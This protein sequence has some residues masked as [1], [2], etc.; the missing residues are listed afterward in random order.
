MYRVTSTIMLVA[1]SL[2][3]AAQGGASAVQLPAQTTLPIVFTSTV[4]AKGAHTGDPV[5]AKTFQT[6]HLQNGATLPLG[7]R[8]V[9]HVA[10]VSAFAYDKTPYAKQKPS[11][12]TVHFDAVEANGA[13]IPLNVTVRAIADVFATTAA[14]EPV[15]SDNDPLGSL[16]LVG[17]EYLIPSQSEVRNMDGDVVA[18][19]RHGGVYAHLI[20][21]GR[22]DGSST[23]VSMGIFAATACGVYGYTNISASEFGTQQNP[24]TL[25]LTSF[26]TSP[27]IWKHSTALLEV[28]PQEQASVR[29]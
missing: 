13:K 15:G 27:G 6:I 17:G 8:V 9:G 16:T 25:T 7:S 29:R 21:N 14:E 23:E 4:T 19:N 26:R 3:A 10:E 24:S 11:I 1:S 2:A 12:L 28:L 22:C 20:S 18:Y 5:F